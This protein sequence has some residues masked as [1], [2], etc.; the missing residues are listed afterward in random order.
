MG[1]WEAVGEAEKSPMLPAK[2][3]DTDLGAGV[4]VCLE[5]RRTFRKT[6]RFVMGLKLFH[7]R[8]GQDC[9]VPVVL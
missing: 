1:T 7:W 3:T 2:R 8:K 9:F 5:S 4:L 6:A